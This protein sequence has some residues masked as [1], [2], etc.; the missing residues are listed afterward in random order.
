MQS[1][2]LRMTTNFFLIKFIVRQ[3]LRVSSLILQVLYLG[4]NKSNLLHMLLFRRCY[5]KLNLKLFRR[6]F[7]ISMDFIKENGYSTDFIHICI[8]KFLDS[9]TRRY[10]HQH[11]HHNDNNNTIIMK[12]KTTIM[13][14]IMWVLSFTV[15]MSIQIRLKLAK[16][17]HDNFP[18]WQLKKLLLSYKSICSSIVYRHAL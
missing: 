14:I 8:K 10:S 6:E 15:K 11:H 17:V 12:I 7:V 2:L 13:I 4:H 5:L 18:F 16:F 9:Y 1:F 3:N